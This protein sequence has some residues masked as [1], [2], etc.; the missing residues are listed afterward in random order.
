VVVVAAARLVTDIGDIAQPGLLGVAACSLV[1]LTG[2]VAT[3]AALRSPELV[4]VQHRLSQW[5]A[6]A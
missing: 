5:W 2:Y 4:P 6:R 1:G 3:H